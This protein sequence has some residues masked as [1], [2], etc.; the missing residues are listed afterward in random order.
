[1]KKSVSIVV[2]AYNEAQ[3]IASLYQEILGVL[4][5]M[6]DY[7][8]EIIFVD[9]GSTDNTKE[10]LRNLS[11]ADR[12]LK[13]VELSRNFGK[14]AA[15]TAGMTHA[16]GDAVILIDADLQ[17]PPVLIHNFIK[18]WENGNDM[19]VG[20]RERNEGEGFIKKIGSKIFYRLMN[21]IGETHFVPYSTDFRLIDRK[22]VTEFL[23]FTE[24]DRMTRGLLD[25]LGFKK[26]YVQFEAN[27]REKGDSGY[28]VS[29][30]FSLAISSFINFSL[31]PLKLASYIG[32][33]ITIFSGVL[34]LFIIIEQIILGDPLNL[35][36]TG[37]AQLVIL[38]L[39]LVGIV[40][41]A[42]GILATYIA[43]IHKEVSGRPLFV[44]REKGNFNE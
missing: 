25:W 12:N 40:L 10:I 8:W 7:D 17:H 38:V 33:A 9:D 41:I 11:S 29:K 3:N 13:Y 32:I 24:R 4:A 42:I 14:E 44:I 39:F 31:I 18:E 28:S 35:E 21:S 19:V 15:T 20:V 6:S 26:T 34:G 2:P 22:V 5:K 27:K 36:F 1:M 37:P 30:L 43:H 16:S 23:R